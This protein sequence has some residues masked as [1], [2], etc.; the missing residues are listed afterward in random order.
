[1]RE[2]IG[3]LSGDGHWAALARGAMR[4]D[5]SGLQRTLTAEVMARGTGDPREMLAAWQQDNA[6]PIER[7]GHVL[8]EMRNLQA[9]DLSMLSVALRE[10]RNL[11]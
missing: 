4:D 2:R 8:A 10:L 3:Q 5:L 1:L 6:G 7:A 11:A 9:P